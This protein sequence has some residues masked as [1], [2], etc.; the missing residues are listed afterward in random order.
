MSLYFVS[1]GTLP[2]GITPVSQQLNPAVVEHL[3]T[4]IYRPD[5][6]RLVCLLPL[7]SIHWDDE[8][9]DVARLMELTEV[10]QTQVWRLF[11]IRLKLWDKTALADEEQQFWTVAVQ[12][13]P[14]CPIFQRLVLSM[15]EQQA[16]AEAEQH[17]AEEFEALFADADQFTVTQDQ[18]GLQKFSATFDLTKGR[19]AAD[20]K[21]PWWK[22][23]FKKRSMHEC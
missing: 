14:E 7:G 12:Q 20:T 11:A 21:R 5:A 16:R 22:R 18:Y 1:V 10:D 15:D 13:V 8:I 19:A 17:C 23:F 4:L 9:P 6:K 3:S 2:K